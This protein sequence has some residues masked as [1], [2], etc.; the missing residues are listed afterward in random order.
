MYKLSRDSKYPATSQFAELDAIR[1]GLKIAKK[2]LVSFLI[3]KHF[4]IKI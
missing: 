1:A 3:K 2:K 4:Y